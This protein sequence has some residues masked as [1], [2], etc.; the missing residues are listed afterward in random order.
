MLP[1]GNHSLAHASFVAEGEALVTAIPK[2]AVRFAMSNSRKPFSDPENNGS[3]SHHAR[4]EADP[5]QT[6][7]L[8]C[9]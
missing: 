2:V 9:V 8:L 3:A 6:F 5:A 7:S 4:G 1:Y